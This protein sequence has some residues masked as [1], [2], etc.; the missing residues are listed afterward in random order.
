MLA[1]RTVWCTVSILPCAFRRD[2]VTEVMVSFTWRIRESSAWSWA[3]RMEASFSL[4]RLRLREP[5]RAPNVFVFVEELRDVG[6]AL[7]VVVAPV[8]EGLAKRSSTSCSSSSESAV[9]EG[10]FDISGLSIMRQEGQSKR[11]T[12]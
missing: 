6:V 2:A 8:V 11:L 12:S 7:F 3:S 4:S 10:R 5:G 9:R 1:F